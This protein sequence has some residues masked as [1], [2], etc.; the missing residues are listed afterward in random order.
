MASLRPP[1]SRA[2]RARRAGPEAPI[3]SEET[4][5]LAEY[6]GVYLDAY[7]FETL[8]YFLT[9]VRRVKLQETL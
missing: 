9:L 7:R 1:A 4:L 2:P 3:D 5:R 6:N 8:E